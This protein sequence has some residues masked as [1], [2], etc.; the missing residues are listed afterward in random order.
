MPDSN[1]R[2]IS[3]NDSLIHC[4][5]NAIIRHFTEYGSSS[6]HSDDNDNS[7]KEKKLNLKNKYFD[8]NVALLDVGDSILNDGVEDGVVLVV[9]NGSSLAFD[10]ITS[11]MAKHEK[12][13]VIFGDTLRLCISVASGST[14][15]DIVNDKD[16]E[17]EYSRRVLWC[18]DN[19]FEYV[20]K[21]DLSASAV[22]LGHDEREK[23]KFA[24]IIEAFSSTVWSTAQMH[25]NGSARS[26]SHTKIHEASSLPPNNV[27][28]YHKEQTT[29]EAISQKQEH[30]NEGN[31]DEA[32][33]NLENLM[34]EAR[35]I[36][37]EATSGRVPDGIRRQRAEDTALK[38][39]EL[40]DSLDFETDEGNESSVELSDNDQ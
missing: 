38:M 40:L 11:V 27:P 28:D 18:L 4:T 22:T 9:L 35:A 20:E 32:M 13:G 10:A 23:E 37:E 21:C 30:T 31:Q 17:N 29:N 1:V 2:F 24:R 15:T 34:S 19:G 39:I 36:R 5:R 14:E 3:C 12:D 26:S 16:Y 33:D 8:A 7:T 25:T 6:N